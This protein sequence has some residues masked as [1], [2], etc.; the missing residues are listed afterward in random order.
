MVIGFLVIT[1][2]FVFFINTFSVL[3]MKQDLDYI[4]KELVKTAAEL[5]Y[6]G[7]DVDFGASNP[8]I[9]D[10]DDDP[11][12]RRFDELLSQRSLEKNKIKITWSVDDDSSWFLDD[13]TVGKQYDPL[14]SGVLD[15]NRNASTNRK[16]QYGSRLN[17]TVEYDFSSSGIGSDIFSGRR[18]SSYSAL[19]QVYWSEEDLDYDLDTFDE[20][21]IIGFGSVGFPNHDNELTKL[22]TTGTDTKWNPDMEFI[23]AGKGYSYV[24]FQVIDYCY[25]VDN[26]KGL[27]NFS[28][29]LSP[30]SDASSGYKLYD[31]EIRDN[32]KIDTYYSV[33][34]CDDSLLSGAYF[35]DPFTRTVRLKKRVS[36]YSQELLNSLP[37]KKVVLRAIAM[38]SD[39]PRDQQPENNAKWACIKAKQILGD[40][41]NPNP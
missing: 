10:K 13:D 5:G 28:M 8:H 38:V 26:N 3:F 19:S 29:D 40:P 2:L 33:V 11:L 24:V 17:A 35:I 30:D 16:V 34:W 32:C 21:H 37:E 31:S 14:T 7:R 1:L 20:G 12:A 27:F 22:P 36:Q 23:F 41:P 25:N 9:T 18:Q 4:A 6:C 15:T 39:S